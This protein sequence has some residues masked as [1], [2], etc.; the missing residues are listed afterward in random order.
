MGISLQSCE[1]LRCLRRRHPDTIDMVSVLRGDGLIRRDTLTIDLTSCRND[2]LVFV[3]DLCL[4]AV[5]P[6]NLACRIVMVTYYHAWD[7]LREDP[8]W[9]LGGA[10]GV[11]WWGCAGYSLCPLSAHQHKQKNLKAQHKLPG[12][13][14]SA[15]RIFFLCMWEERGGSCLCC[16]NKHVYTPVI[17]AGVRETCWN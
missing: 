14:E 3:K 15:F 11:R 9:G 1:S 7:G 5:A 2:L 16:Q 10:R 6:L 17:A 8:W 12:K 13:K 4:S